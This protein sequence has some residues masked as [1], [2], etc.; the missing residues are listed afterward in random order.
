LAVFPVLADSSKDPAN[1]G[2]ILLR[3]LGLSDSDFIRITGFVTDKVLKKGTINQS[4]GFKGSLDVG[5]LV[6]NITVPVAVRFPAYL[7]KIK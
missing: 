3:F 2:W 1:T 4:L 5:K 7:K 6:H